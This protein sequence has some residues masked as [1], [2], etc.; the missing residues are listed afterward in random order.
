MGWFFTK[1]WIRVRVQNAHPWLGMSL[2]IR[3]EELCPKFP[4]LCNLQL[5]HIGIGGVGEWGSQWHIRL[6]LKNML[7]TNISINVIGKWLL[8]NSFCV[9]AWYML[10]FLLIVNWDCKLGKKAFGT[11]KKLGICPKFL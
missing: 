1:S 5:G 7:I 2:K 4:K 9:L 8:F 10:H 3:N 11:D 6:Y